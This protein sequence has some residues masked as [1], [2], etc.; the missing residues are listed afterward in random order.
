MDDNG[1]DVDV[2]REAFV[3]FFPLAAADGHPE[4]AAYRTAAPLRCT[5]INISLVRHERSPT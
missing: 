1:L 5:D 3:T 2:F 4:Y